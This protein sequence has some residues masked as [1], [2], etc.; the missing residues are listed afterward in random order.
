MRSYFATLVHDDE[1]GG[2]SAS[3]HQAEELRILPQMGYALQSN[4]EAFYTVEYSQMIFFRWREL[5]KVAIFTQTIVLTNECF[6]DGEKAIITQRSSL[7]M[8]SHA[9]KQPEGYR[10]LVS[11]AQSHLRRMLDWLKELLCIHDA[12]IGHH[13]STKRDFVFSG[14]RCRSSRPGCGH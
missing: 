7:S 2:A 10:L 1:C 14:W 13:F 6:S 11:F 9:L 3:S 8:D 12:G 4:R 5:S